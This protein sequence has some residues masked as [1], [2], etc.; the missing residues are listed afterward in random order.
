[1]Y[2]TEQNA[3]IPENFTGQLLKGKSVIVTGCA[4]EMGIG[5]AVAILLASHGAKVAVVDID[6]DRAIEIARSLGSEHLGIQCDITKE[7]D[8]KTVADKTKNAFGA[9]D[10]LVNNAG[11]FAKKPFLDISIEEFDRIMHINAHGTFL[12]TRAVLPIML[13]QGDGNMIFVSSTAAQRGGGVYGSSH[14]IASK[15]AMSAFALGIAR[16]Y[17]AQGIRSNVLAPNLIKTDSVL[18]MSP[19]QRAAIEKN[20]P[21]QR[22]GSIWDV[23]GSALFLAS[24]LSAYITGATIDINGGFHIR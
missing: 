2:T 13:E 14:Y 11:I 21:L 1:M 23:A 15:G 24:D 8:C 4:A 12:M 7:S 5:R 22:S 10:V 18:D 9:V 16:E 20:V 17:G 19:E 3:V 6:G